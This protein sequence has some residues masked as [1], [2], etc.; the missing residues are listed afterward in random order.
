MS[1]WCWGGEGCVTVSRFCIAA[2]QY[3]PGQ[4]L[5]Q[6]FLHSTHDWLRRQQRKK[7]PYSSFKAALDNRREVGGGNPSSLPAP[8]PREATA[9]GLLSSGYPAPVLHGGGTPETDP[10]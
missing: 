1:C 2:P 7:I 5:V 6:N 10:I 3:F 9:L 8:P 4:P